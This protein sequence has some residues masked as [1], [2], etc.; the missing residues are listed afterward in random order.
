MDDHVP[1]A[2]TTGL[3]R[4]GIDVLTSQ[5]DG[6]TELDDAL[7]LQ[8]ATDLGRVLLTQDQDFLQIAPAWQ[9]A[10]M[11]F[12]TVVYSH[13]QGPGIGEVIADMELILSTAEDA[14]LWNGLIHLPLR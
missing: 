9:R 7:L 5:E 6:T 11:P 14:E 13:Q 8:R 10:G 12:R 2:V 3:R 4:C 1:I